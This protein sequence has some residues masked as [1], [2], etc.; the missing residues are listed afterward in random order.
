MEEDYRVS[1][2]ELAGSLVHSYRETTRITNIRKKSFPSRKNVIRTT[3]ELR[4]LLFPGYL[5]RTN[6]CWENVEYH[7]GAT[8]DHLFNE[9]SDEIAKSFNHPS[10]SS[11]NTT[12]SECQARACR[13]TLVFFKKIPAIRELLEDDVQAAFDGD[14]AARDIDEVIFS[15]PCV[16]AI[17]IF[18]IA[19]ELFLQG[20]PLIPRMMTEYAHSMTGIDIHPGATIGR[21]FFIDHGTGVVIGE[22]TVIGESVKIY[23]GVTLGALSIPRDGRGHVIRGTKRHPTIA[24]NVTIY[25][26]ATILGGETKIGE[27]SVVGGNV[28]L[29]DSIPPHTKII[30]EEPRLRILKNRES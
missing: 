24:D 5:G 4:E 2:G 8:L 6:L 28:W 11:Q 7:V 26:G 10:H 30:I 20:I 9:M 27:G 22:T 17:S 16:V 15:Y 18:R 1:I 21:N 3:E 25:A 23:Q 29:T 19:H 13:E 12:C 14:P